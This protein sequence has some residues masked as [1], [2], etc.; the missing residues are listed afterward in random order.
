MTIEET[1]LPGVKIITPRVFGD[2]RGYFKEIYQ[3]VRYKDCGIEED[4]VQ[5]NFSR[6][7]AG[8]LRGLHFQ[9]QKAQGKLVQALTGRIYDVVVDITPG[10]ATFGEW[11]GVELTGENHKQL[12]VPPGYAHGF[13][14]FDERNDVLYKCTEYY[15]PEYEHTLM[16]NDP[17]VGIDWPCENPT[18]TGKDAAGID[19][20]RVAEI[21]RAYA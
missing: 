6:S 12:Y 16:W 4:F 1:K 15:A 8:V 3:G 5:D 19:L 17:D 14:T 2:D 18:L 10:S 20:A 11:L 13:V 21:M 9:E 7:S